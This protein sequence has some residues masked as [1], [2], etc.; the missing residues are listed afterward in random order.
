M[1]L[2][3]DSRS[4]QIMNLRNYGDSDID[5]MRQ[6]EKLMKNGFLDTRTE[7]YGYYQIDYSVR[8]HYGYSY[9]YF[10]QAF[11]LYTLTFIG[12]PSDDADFYPEAILKIYDSNGELIK[13]FQK[14]SSFNQTASLYYGHDPTKRAERELNKLFSDIQQSANLQSNEINRALMAA[15]PITREKDTN[16]KAKIASNSKSGS[17]S[18]TPS[19]TY[20]GGSTSSSSSSQQTQKTYIVQITYEVSPGINLTLPYHIKANSASEAQILAEGQWRSGNFNNKKFLYSAV[21]GSY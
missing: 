9:W 2:T 10:L 7:E 15:G 12:V 20:S 1:E 16:A 14:T 13:D 8:G 18:S 21:T 5:F 6:S 3:T 4:S 19:Y 11:F 17:S